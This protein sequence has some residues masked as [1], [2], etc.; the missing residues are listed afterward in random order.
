MSRAIRRD[1]PA[2]TS[3]LA[4]FDAPGGSQTPTPVIEAIAAALSAPLSNR[5]AD[6]PAQRNAEQIVLEARSA[7]ADYL[8]N[9]PT[10]IVF[11]RSATQLTL[12]FA[13]T[14]ARSWAPGGR[15]RGHPARSRRQHPP[16][17]AGRRAGRGDRTVGGFR[18]GYRG[19]RP[20]A[21]RSRPDPADP[22][23]RGHRRQQPAGHHPGSPADRRGS[24]TGSVR[25]CGWT[26]ST[27]PPTSASIGLPSA[28]TSWSARRTSSVVRT[29]VCWPPTPTCWPG[30]GPDKLLP[31]SDVVP[32]RF[33]LGTL[34]YE[35]LAGTTAAVN[36]LAG[37]GEGDGPTGSSHP[38]LR[39]AGRE[40]ARASDPARGGAAGPGRQDLQ[41]GGST[42]VDGAVRPA[43]TDRR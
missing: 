3:G 2:L 22:A 6:N 31:S 7:M 13:R 30:C 18:S 36:Y 5:G 43:G 23:G 27:W 37:L 24:S 8:G 15:G 25:C 21:A 9:D 29:S 32:E 1:F 41:P 19:A 40:R 14:L 20:R 4:F 38:G 33:E 12:E 11:G 17:A 35:L 34:P 28:P 42:D 10:G 16:V 39:P 26:P